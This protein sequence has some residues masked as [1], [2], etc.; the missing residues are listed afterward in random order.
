MKKIYKA[1][2]IMKVG[3]RNI[4]VCDTSVKGVQSEQRKRQGEISTHVGS[5]KYSNYKNS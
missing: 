5:T 4:K 2:V 3:D 1:E